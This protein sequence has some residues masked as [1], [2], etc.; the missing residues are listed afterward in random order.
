MT[1]V[2]AVGWGLFAAA[3]LLLALL[4]HQ[5]AE[6]ALHRNRVRYWAHFVGLAL[7]GNMYIITSIFVILAARDPLKHILWVQCA[8][9]GSLMDMIAGLVLIIRGVLPFSQAGDVIIINLILVPALLIFYP[10]RKASTA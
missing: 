7:L 1:A 9:A 8:I 6:S 10:W 2:L 4:A 3:M 5:R